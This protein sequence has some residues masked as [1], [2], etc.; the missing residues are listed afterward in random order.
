KNKLLEELDQLRDAIRL[1]EQQKGHRAIVCSDQALID[2]AETRPLKISDFLAI[3]GIGKVFMTKYSSRF[4]QVILHHQQASV[5]EVDVSK[6]AYK[7][8]DHYKDR[9]TNISRRNPNL[10]QGRIVRRSTFDMS[11]LGM[12][13]EL[14][15]FLTSKRQSKLPL[16]FPSSYE[17]EQLERHITVLYRE[18][19]KEEKETGSYDLYLAYPYVEGVFKRDQFAI[20]APLL[21][22]PVKLVRNKRDFSIH[23]VHDRDILF[24]RDLLLAISKFEQNDV[25]SKAPY[26]N[27]FNSNVLRDVVIPFYEKNGLEIK[28]TKANFEFEP[29][30][31]E[32]KDQFVKR[33]KG[34]FH[35]KEYI[36]LGRYKL[37]SSMIQKD[38]TLILEA[39]KYNDLL[40][41]LIEESNLYSEE[42]NTAFRL[43]A[44]P[45][46][47]RHIS[48]INDVNYAQEKV[49]DLLHDE[50]KL[51]IWG[52]PGTGKSQT[53]T[54]LIAASVLQ[55]KNVLV[56]SEKKVALDVIYSRLKGASKY[57]MFIDDP[58]NKQDFYHKLQAFINPT[59]PSRTINNDVYQ[60]E[61]DI[62]KILGD[63]DR[64]LDLMYQESIQYIPIHQLYRRYLKDKDVNPDLT[65]KD[66]HLIFK[67]VFGTLK[68]KDLRQLEETFDTNG[69]LRDVFLY[70]KMRRAYPILDK[71]ETKIT[72]S[73]RLELETFTEAF[74]TFKE[75]Y[76]QSWFFKKRRLRKA[77]LESNKK[78]ILYLT[79]KWFTD[80]QYLKLLLKDSA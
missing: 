34:I 58:D 32:L 80:T 28:E 14:I 68:F 37:Y 1:E 25:D 17:G 13:M 49:I 26:I 74:N 56:V 7:I 16:A 11:S 19:N 41:G 66:V 59:P 3:S 22:F 73:N 62:E 43:D 23:K 61:E 48:Y 39:N 31:K 12:D 47:E 57:A 45:I 69:H 18:T 72:R 30:Q 6:N 24:N 10:Y 8:L 50:E 35:I 71:L 4:L 42:K 76:N 36:T 63:M 9:L 70:E 65:P 54:S 79:N 15:K 52:P 20:K 33:R 75:Q 38:M 2:M 27:E 53:I 29:F 78:R 5:K 21:Y 77:F 55:G 64:A 44:K 51:V 46:N 67:S 60:L 40:E